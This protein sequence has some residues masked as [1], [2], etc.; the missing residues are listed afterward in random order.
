[1]E[2][3]LSIKKEK[4]DQM[5]GNDKFYYFQIKNRSMGKNKQSKNQHSEKYLQLKSQTMAN[6]SHT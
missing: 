6:L 5:K 3:V 4:K 2:S 1:M